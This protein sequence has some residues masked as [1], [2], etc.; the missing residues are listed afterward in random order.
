M[1]WSGTEDFRRLRDHRV[2]FIL[3][4]ELLGR[5]LESLL[6]CACFSLYEGPE[7][8]QLSQQ[9]ALFT[10]TPGFEDEEDPAGN[11]KFP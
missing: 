7:N 3:S 9:D 10:H 5:P 8:L 2:H 11:C 4:S 6:S 1:P